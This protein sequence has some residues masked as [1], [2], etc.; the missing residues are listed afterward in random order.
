M[1]TE[2]NV[3]KARLYVMDTDGRQRREITIKL[4]PTLW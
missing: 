1:T 4:S 3:S 2:N